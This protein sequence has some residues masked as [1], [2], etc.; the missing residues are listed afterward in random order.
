MV[1]HIHFIGRN[2]E[3]NKVCKPS[4]FIVKSVQVLVKG[5]EKRIASFIFLLA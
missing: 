1:D 3:S 2:I 4:V 5:K